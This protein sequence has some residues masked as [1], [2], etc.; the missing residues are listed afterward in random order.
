LLEKNKIKTQKN[1]TQLKEKKISKKSSSLSGSKPSESTRLLSI[2]Y[3]AFEYFIEEDGCFKI[4]KTE[5]DVYII[6][7]NKNDE[8]ATLSNKSSK[9]PI[10]LWQK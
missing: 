7:R 5:D 1:L 8:N 10:L 9:N 2:N 6:I 4:Y 3:A